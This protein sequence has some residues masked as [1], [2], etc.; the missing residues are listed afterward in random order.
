M[1]TIA[2]KWSASEITIWAK[3]WVITTKLK[4]N[5]SLNRVKTKTESLDWNCLKLA[6]GITSKTLTML[7]SHFLSI[8]WLEIKNSKKWMRFQNC[9][10]Q[11]MYWLNSE[12]VDQITLNKIKLTR[13][14]FILDLLKKPMLK[15]CSF[16]P[17]NFVRICVIWR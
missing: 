17:S 15:T 12:L 9:V 2:T 5:Q 7:I 16:N 11:T 1:L 13:D 3:A 8:Q 10:D 14:N 6:I 4:G